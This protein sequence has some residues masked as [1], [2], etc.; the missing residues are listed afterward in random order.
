[1]TTTMRAVRLTI[2]AWVST[3]LMLIIGAVGGLILGL[4]RMPSLLFTFP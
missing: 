1:M 4:L 2:A 3:T